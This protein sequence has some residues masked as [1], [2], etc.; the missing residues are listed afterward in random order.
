MSIGAGCGI[1]NG[2][3][4]SNCVVM[5]GVTVKDHTKVL[6]VCLC[7]CVCVCGYVCVCLCCVCVCCV[8]V[9]VSLCLRAV[10]VP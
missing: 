7:V 1:G 6:C 5:R 2:V 3:R 9:L 4:L 10:V 8:S